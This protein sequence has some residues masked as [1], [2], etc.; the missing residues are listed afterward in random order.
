VRVLA[1]AL[2]VA[3][4]VQSPS[5]DAPPQP[6]QEPVDPAA[7]VFATTTGLMLHA[8]KPDAVADY[9]AAVA[10]LQGA[11]AASEDPRVKAVASGWRVFRAR[12]TGDKGIV[13]YVHVLDPAVAGVDYRPSQWLD[14]L[15]DGAPEE[16]LAKYRAA[17]AAPPTMLSL[18]ELADMTR[19]PAHTPGSVEDARDRGLDADVDRSAPAARRPQR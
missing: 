5:P 8:I 1:A 13:L 14:D 6:P 16:L 7:A 17:F 10:A 2:V 15:L 3:L 18:S 11:M 12:E 19:V 9:E 4:A